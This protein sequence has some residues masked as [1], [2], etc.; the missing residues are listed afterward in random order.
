MTENVKIDIHNAYDSVVYE[1]DYENQVMSIY[2]DNTIDELNKFMIE[3]TNCFTYNYNE[4]KSIGV[5]GLMN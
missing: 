4:E 5:C 2:W 3:E 1:Y